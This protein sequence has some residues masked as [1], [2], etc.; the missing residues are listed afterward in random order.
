MVVLSPKDF[1]HVPAYLRP[2][3]SFR[4]DKNFAKKVQHVKKY[5]VRSD[6]DEVGDVVMIL[7]NMRRVTPKVFKSRGKGKTRKNRKNQ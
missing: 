6:N 5:G 4:A 1:K 7:N 3:R 2:K